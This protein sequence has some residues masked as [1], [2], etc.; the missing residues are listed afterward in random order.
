MNKILHEFLDNAKRKFLAA[1]D[2]STRSYQLDHTPRV[3]SP[4]TFD[5][6]INHY[7]SLILSNRK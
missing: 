1:N 5:D 7:E 3:L 6:F 4:V 2:S